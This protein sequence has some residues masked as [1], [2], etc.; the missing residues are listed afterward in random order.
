M[1]THPRH[2]FDTIIRQNIDLFDLISPQIVGHQCATQIRNI[3]L[4]E[5]LRYVSGGDNEVRRIMRVR[6]HAVVII[7]IVVVSIV[8]FD[9]NDRHSL[10]DIDVYVSVF[11]LITL[12]GFHK[13]TL[14]QRF[15]DASC[16]DKS[17]WFSQWIE[18]APL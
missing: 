12:G 10:R 15:F 3:I 7:Y 11:G 4:C 14:F 1:F 17:H 6:H 5:P 8:G 2:Q 18:A 9:P 16:I 13:R